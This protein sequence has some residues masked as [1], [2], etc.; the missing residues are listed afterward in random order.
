MPTVPSVTGQNPYDEAVARL[1]EAPP[2]DEAAE[3]TAQ[4][5]AITGDATDKYDLYLSNLEAQRE[6]AARAAGI[7]AAQHKPD[8]YVG[9]LDLSKQAGLPVGVVESNPEA[10]RQ[11]LRLQQ[12][13]DMARKSPQVAAW[14]SVADNAVLAQDDLEPLSMLE[15]ALRPLGDVAMASPNEFNRAFASGIRGL[16][17]LNDALA[18]KIDQGLRAV[19]LDAVADVGQTEIPWWANPSN[20]ARGAG[21]WLEDTFVVDLPEERRNVATDISGGLG[22]LVAQILVT[23]VNPIAGGTMMVGQGADNQ[24]QRADEAGADQAAKSDAVLM[25]ATITAVTEKMGLDLLL[26]R[27]P[28]AIKNRYASYLAD[29]LIAGGIEFKQ[30]GLEAIANNAVAQ[31]LYDPESGLMDGVAYDATIGGT[32]GLIAR[33]VLGTR[34]RR[35]ESSKALSDQQLLDALVGNAQATKLRERDP[36]RYAELVAT[37][38][39][40]G[41]DTVYVPV[42]EFQRYFQSAAM[43]PQAVAAEAGVSYESYQ[44]AVLTGG[45]VAIPM[46]QYLAKV[47]PEHHKALG[48]FARMTPGGLTPAEAKMSPEEL[49]QEVARFNEQVNIEA[50]SDR[51]VYDDVYGMLMGT[52]RFE[53]DAVERYATLTNAFFRT[54]SEREGK[55]ALALYEPYRLRIKSEL[56]AV[57]QDS[58]IDVMID[59]LIERLRVGDIPTDRD[60]YG[61]S[62]VDFLVARGGL[63]VDEGMAGEVRRVAES[64]RATRKGKPRLVRDDGMPLD[65]ALEA[66]VESGYLPQGADIQALLDALDSE[67]VTDRP[68]FAASG[69]DTRKAADREALLALGDELDRLGINTAEAT[70][71]AIK[72]ALFGGG[73]VPEALVQVFD[74][75]ASAQ[76][77]TPE[78]RRWFGDSKVVDAEGRPLVVYHGSNKPLE[79]IMSAAERMQKFDENTRGLSETLVAPERSALEKTAGAMWF[80]EDDGVA[81][82][83]SGQRDGVETVTEVYLSIQN[84]LDLRNADV[85]EVERILTE[86]R[87][88]DVSI[89]LEYGESKGI[90]QAI[91]RDNGSLV[92]WAKK[93]GYDGLIYPDTD[94]RGRGLHT[95]YVTFSPGQIKSAT[96]NRGTFDPNNPSI[97]EQS[98]RT[99]SEAIRRGYIAWNADRQF[100]IG[101]TKD[102]DLT[103]FLHESGHFFLEVMGDLAAQPD[104]SDALKADYAAILNWLGVES[105]DQVGVEQHEKLARGFEAY[106]GEG[107]APT[108]ELAGAFARFR[109]WVLAV[110]RSLRNLNVELSDEVRGVFD[111]MLATDAEI[112]AAE[113]DMGYEP[114]F[115]EAARAGMTEA[116]FATYLRLQEEA[117]REA[118]EALAAKAIKQ[119][120]DAQEAERDDLRDE[121]AREVHAMPVYQALYYLSRGKLPDGSPLPDG[122]EPGKLD[123]NILRDRYGQEFL[124]RYLL[125]RGVYSN[126][127]GL[128]P[129]LLATAFGFP[130]GDKLV[131]ALANAQPMKAYIEARVDQRLRERYGDMVTDGSLPAEA[132][133]AVHNTRRM[134][135]L[136]AEVQALGRLTGQPAPSSAQLRRVAEAI[137]AGVKYRSLQPN[138]YLRAERRA[139][140]EAMQAATRGDMGRALEAKRRQMLNAHLYDQAVKVKAE[141][142]KLLRYV[143]RFEKGPLRERLGKTGRLEQVDAMLDGYDL[144]R[145]SG[146]AIDRN[147]AK[148]ELLS[149]ILAGTMVAPKAVVDQLKTDGTRTNWQELTVENMRG[150]RDVLAQ[151]EAETRAEYE[152][153]VN[154]EKVL[155]D[156]KA[157]AIA[158]DTL[159]GGEEVA[160]AYGQE[161]P[162]EAV[163]RYGRNALMAWLRPATLARV[164][165]GNKDTGGWTNWVIEPIR[166][167]VVEK[168]EPMRRDAQE[169]LAKLMADHFSV[170]EISRMHER[171]VVPG[172]EVSLSRWDL[173]G[174]ALN[175]G[176]AENRKAILESTFPGSRQ[177]FTQAGIENALSTLTENE[178]SYVQGAWDLVDSYWPQIEAAQK[179]RKGIAPPKVQAEPFV[180]KLMGGGEITLRGG[181]YPLK[182]NGRLNAKARNAE[183]EDAWERMRAGTLSSVQTK[184]GHTIERVGSGGQPV[185]LSINVLYGHVNNVVMD[186]ALADEVS[187]V[188]RVLRRPQVVDALIR[189]G[190]MDALETFKLWLKD[191][192]VGDQA[193]RDGW[194]QMAQFIRFGF[195]KSKIGFNLMTVGLQITGLPQTIVVV[196]KKAFALGAASY[197]KNPRQAVAQVMEQSAFMKARY[198]LNA[199]NRDISDIQRALTS[200]APPGRGQ[201][202]LGNF[203]AAVRTLQMPAA[204]VSWAFAGIR[205]TQMQVDTVTWLAGYEG[206]KAQGM[207]HAAAVQYADGMV[208]K[209]QTSGLFQD[210]AGIER[211]TLSQTVR[212]AEWVKLLTTLQSVMIAKGNIGYEAYKRTD[213]KSVPSVLSF[214]LDIVMLFTVEGI[215]VAA[216]RGEWPEEEDDWFGWLLGMTAES[217]AGTIPVVREIPSAA[218]GFN[219]GGPLG[220]VIN[221]VVR[222]AKQTEQAELDAA[223]IKSYMNIIG[224]ATGLPSA[225]INRAV[226]AYWRE[227]VEGEDVAAIEYV[228]G[229][230]GN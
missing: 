68:V 11:D 184:Y 178:W 203:L 167:A 208:E 71:A 110:Y 73:R 65:S 81:Y 13:A 155:L 190:N 137:V 207:D 91:V 57:L 42:E 109:G 70:N 135:A 202:W 166:R 5:A 147:K 221:D 116:Q 79:R 12:W 173:I 9:L 102:A 31:S 226:D 25:G 144:R 28:P 123:G 171:S 16:G 100:T 35:A 212:Q 134:K 129:D 14:L 172:L 107:K 159:T 125:R 20:W 80:T 220:G 96:G 8:E 214:S 3:R 228:T 114:L 90:A 94:V 84:P 92:Q 37:L 151:I 27:V 78:F 199:F 41:A 26:D 215:L 181:Y 72:Q 152:A 44:E 216:L 106:L 48:E 74:Q 118:Q 206:G 218:K 69:R 161:A 176:N 36:A 23:R 227:F 204:A 175:W 95:S 121:V 61:L 4:V 83:Y 192:A 108:A 15:A 115:N 154:G 222:A 197:T 101:L 22:N 43:D 211:G 7:A 183:L 1:G 124:N 86:A 38:A 62:L 148:G 55:D 6:Q 213:F 64:D 224:T 59:P 77:D 119:V 143:K 2:R 45:D 205:V 187:Y 191:V 30:E 153:M 17:D 58:Q 120:R 149:A 168:L 82:G 169:R 196:G 89:G 52:G 150:L 142:E 111:R 163:R 113:R 179:R 19:G 24:A 170:K 117:R 56:P 145:L 76:T 132:V 180:Q 49:A 219:T 128:D 164:L 63:M 33:T 67:L 98:N 50:G 112:Q 210:R 60:A 97:L 66:A 122:M 162:D 34:L 201:G 138:S 209:A 188:D 198:E 182:Y 186:L 105:R 85:V 75:G 99:V 21:D 230:R 18:F 51:R 140:R 177:P 193:A 39:K 136:E 229:R 53:R 195:T 194:S 139:A 103:T 223:L 126:S 93:N 156:E 189:T 146:R 225:Q 29:K 32:V 130:S 200:G 160:L 54:M 165:Q 185:D 46:A 40:P 10:V 88:K 133:A 104:A 157:D 174:I 131:E 158:G 87:G 141:G 217:M 47:G 127:G